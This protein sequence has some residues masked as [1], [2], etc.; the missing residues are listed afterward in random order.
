M[1]VVPKLCCWRTN[2]RHW[3]G[4]GEAVQEGPHQPFEVNS[5]HRRCAPYAIC[6]K[7]YGSTYYAVVLL[8]LQQDMRLHPSR[9]PVLRQ[10]LNSVGVPLKLLLLAS[11]PI[12]V[13]VA[14]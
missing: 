1:E 9:A 5:V 4:G 12:R 6:V 2:Q 13:V 14:E 7:L 10:L 8:K 11:R 3:Q